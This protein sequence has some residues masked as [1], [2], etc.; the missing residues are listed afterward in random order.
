MFAGAEAAFEALETLLGEGEWFF[1]A[2]GPGM[3]DAAVFAY[4]HLILDLHVGLEG[5]LERFDGL[6]R[7]RGRIL[8]RYFHSSKKSS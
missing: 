6:V 5:V 7:H 1:G 2:R 3:L 8:M 4:T